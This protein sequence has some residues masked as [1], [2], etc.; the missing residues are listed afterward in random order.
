M[1]TA[2]IIIINLVH[3][4]AT[5]LQNTTNISGYSKFSLYKVSVENMQLHLKK[6]NRIQFDIIPTILECSYSYTFKSR[7]IFNFKNNLFVRP[8]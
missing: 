1:A 8:Y 2:I 6:F 7:R 4:G 3:L 5:T